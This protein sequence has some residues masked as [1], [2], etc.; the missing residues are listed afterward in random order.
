M[1]W[2]ITILLLVIGIPAVILIAACILEDAANR[3]DINRDG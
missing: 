3:R 1:L 2:G